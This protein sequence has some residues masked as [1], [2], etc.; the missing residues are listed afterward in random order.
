MT[1]CSPATARPARSTSATIR[2]HGNRVRLQRDGVET[3][4]RHRRLPGD[5]RPRTS[6]RHR[7][8]RPRPRRSTTSPPAST[9]TPATIFTHSA[10]PALNQLMLPFLSLVSVAELER[11]PTV[12]AEAAASGVDCRRCC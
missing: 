10:V 4:A 3:F 1:A 7:R 12:K 5:H 2:H 9:R 8:Q 6:R 11:N